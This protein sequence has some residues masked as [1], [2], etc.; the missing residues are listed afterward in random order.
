[1]SI[2]LSDLYFQLSVRRERLFLLSHE[3]G[4]C[5]LAEGPSGPSAFQHCWA[6]SS[7]EE[8]PVTCSQGQQHTH[9][10][11]C[12]PGD[13][14]VLACNKSAWSVVLWGQVCWVNIY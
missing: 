4:M 11:P 13:L 8:G 5:T 7:P 3:C 10:L 1:M 6:L 12:V 9:M 2:P 14:C